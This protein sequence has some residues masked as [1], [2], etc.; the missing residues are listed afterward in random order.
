MYIY[1]YMGVGFQWSIVA[2]QDCFSSY[3]EVL[4]TY[5]YNY[6]ELFLVTPSQKR[7]KTRML[8]FYFS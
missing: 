8:V 6:D 5:I 3:F 7:K 4:N 2:M 1:I